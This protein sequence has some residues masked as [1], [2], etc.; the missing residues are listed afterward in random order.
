M[1]WRMVT[2]ALIGAVAG[3]VVAFGGTDPASFAAVEILLF[4]L[5]G[6]A[7][8]IEPR[9]GP[10]KWWLGP[11]ML[12]AYLACD[13]AIVRPA[14]YPARAQMLAVAACLCGFMIVARAAR[15]A[16][17]RRS[18]WVVLVALG[19]G[20]AL[21]GLVQ[22]M[23]GWQQVL[24]FE[25]VV[26]TA[27]AT[28]TYINPNNFAGLIEMLLPLVFARTLWEFEQW[29]ANSHGT[30][31][32]AALWMREDNGPRFAF[33]LFGTLL[34]M[35]ALLFSRS[36]AG[37]AAAWAGVLLVAAVWTA[38]RRRR[39]A[40][41]AIVLSLV[42]L[43]FAAGAW[44]GLEPVFTRFRSAEQDLP[45]RVA[46]WKDTV[47]LVRAHP[48]WGSGPGSFEDAYT[49]V[50]TSGLTMR[51]NHAHDDYL[52]FAAEWGVP[53]ALVLFGLVGF[54]LFRALRGIGRTARAADRF[55]LLGCCGGLCSVLLHAVVDFNLHIPANALLFAVLA[56]L[57]WSLSAGDANSPERRGARR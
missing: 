34:L 41:L 15:D 30:R 12:L 42:V 54:V 10:R 45:S 16:E 13:I 52:E 38:R 36:R 29:A 53:G 40:A 9:E 14:A 32:N 3:A 35:A 1:P 46:V 51:L 26:Y 2:S 19:L 8:W 6:C 5:A 39:S 17:A 21:Y 57:A 20:E 7:L 48:Y 28:G 56:G 24:A 37:I 27:Q 18:I 49:R 11:A 44:I 25:K 23:T 33:F 22:Y 43:T 4:V 50:Q 31:R 47:K 55:L